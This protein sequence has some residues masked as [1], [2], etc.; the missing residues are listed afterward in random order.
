MAKRPFDIKTTV[1]LPKTSFPMK[2]DLPRREPRMIEAWDRL[3]IYD[4][5]RKAR[6]GRP[7]FVLH[8]GPPYANGHIHL[9]QTL[10]KVLKDIVVKSRTMLGFDAPYVP[11]WD[12]HGLPIEH[13]VDKDLGPRKASMTP[14]QV[15]AACRTYAERFIG[16]QREEFRR[17]GVFGEWGA[18]YL[19]LEP[20]YEATIV[21]QIGRFVT[22][23]NIYR[24]KRSVHWCPQCATALAEAEVEYE[25]HVSPSI[26]VR[27]PWEG[28][29]VQSRV[30]ALGGRTPSILIWTTT[31]WT[32]PAN[33]AIAFHPDLDY[34]LIDVG[35][36]VL[37]I[38]ADLAP[39]VLALKGLKTR[40]I[41]ATLRGRD[42]EGLGTAR[43]PYPFA[44]GGASRLVL[45]DY[46]TRDTGTGAVHTAPG[47]GL[48]DFL[49]GRKYGLPIV[50]PVDERGRFVEGTG[51]F[52]GHRVFDANAEIVADLETRGLL[53]HAQT[54][55]H[56]YPHCWRCKKP[57][58]FRATEQWWIA[59]DHNDL[60]R[61][62]LESI[63]KVRWIPPSGSLRIGGM[64]ETRPDWCISRQRVWGVPLPFAFCDA[65][66]TEVVD[67]GLVARTAELF[68]ARGS[69]AWFVPEEF[70]RLVEGTRCPRCDGGALRPGQE[71]V[72]VWF[73]SGVS[74]LALLRQ[75]DGYP[76]P[77]DLYLE[78]SDQ[79][80]GW[81]HSSLLVAVNDRD[82][83]PYRAVL[84]HGFTLDGAGRK[85]SKSLG[86]VISPQE[87]IARHGGDVLRLWVA[88][89]N[90][91]EDMRL[92]E[93]I[94]TR[95]AEAYR[96]IRNTCRFL[97][98]NLH[99]FEPARDARPL[100]SLEEI[101]RFILHR[102]NDLVTR[103]RDAYEA[104]EFHIATQAVHRFSTV[105]LSALYLDILKDR[106]YTDRPDGPARRSA[107]TAMR[108]VLEALTRL[109]APVLCF[110]AE[111]VWQSLH[112][113]PGETLTSTVHTETFPDPV[114]LPPDEGL[115]ARWERL[116]AVRD[117]VLK[118]IET[119][120]TAGVLGNSLEA[121]VIL[122][123]PGELSALLG[124]YRD[125][126]RYL[127]IVSAVDL[128]AVAE[129]AHASAT[130][131][132]LKVGVER[133]PGRKCERCWNLAP[134][135]GRDDEYPTLCQRCLPVVRS[136]FARSGDGT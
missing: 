76:W 9:G 30:P 60:R 116:L 59:L 69:D 119:V 49:T 54:L 113:R 38:A 17:L 44:T 47:H 87:V 128:G 12:C 73:E 106:L 55:T 42:L 8:D 26:Y 10:N 36:E 18:P 39:A 11:G 40:A 29:E 78:G 130:I 52:S 107:Q 90:F 98:G 33:V 104:Y 101:D 133:A 81:F 20:A 86:N 84:T 63:R 108:L 85:M 114:P 93:E 61:R 35:D 48:E 80:R 4:A 79:H 122:E 68:R 96:K 56:S 110:T 97:L 62:A 6:A 31:P 65:C 124:G 127:F 99:D 53:Y 22:H 34:Q 135:V 111:E 94:L 51:A 43:S 23:G 19:T 37:L 91:L 132:G 71:I 136:L 115:V 134:E 72:D 74:Y 67:A 70:E 15:R 32:L 126:L 121:K 83:A 129:P 105:T 89:I 64:I 102:L 24:D 58:L 46:V 75:R 120:R 66:G 112:G 28:A 27:F 100:E 103:V 92:S 45:A 7:R 131:P 13:Q 50:S 82:E 1:N 14:L 125:M 77:S 2:A 25:D 57:I 95:N 3:G 21:E 117:E 118:A 41:L 16:V 123:A 5:I 88:T 109:M